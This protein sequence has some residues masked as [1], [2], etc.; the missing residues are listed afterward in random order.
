MKQNNTDTKIRKPSLWLCFACSVFIHVLIVLLIF[1]IRFDTA[2]RKVGYSRKGVRFVTVA[3][4]QEKEQQKIAKT[5]EKEPSF[6]KT[7]HEQESPVRPKNPD[8]IGSR[9][10]VASGNGKS[11][12][13]HSERNLPNTDGEKNRGEIVLFDQE[14]QEGNLETEGE[15]ISPG[16]AVT[17]PLSAEN[18][19]TENG[20]LSNPMLPSSF[21]GEADPK[22]LDKDDGEPKENRENAAPSIKDHLTAEGDGFRLTTP[23]D[24]EQYMKPTVLHEAIHGNLPEETFMRQSQKSSSRMPYDPSFTASSQP[25]F[26]TKEKRTR[27]TGRFVLGSNP[28][29]NVEK[30]P[31]G[32]YQALIYRRIAYYWYRECDANRDMIIPG[33]LQVRLLVNVRGQITS[34]DVEKRTGASVSQQGFTF[35]AIRCAEIPPMPTEVQ[36][37]IVGDKM[38]LIFDFYFD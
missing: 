21:A 29:L 1:P 17:Q 27:T 8:Y 6:V 9:H 3:R 35:R 36:R 14:R 24:L 25:G 10:T 16:A 22:R 30:T 33:S 18:L 11:A 2:A 4:S 7:A 13:E 26:R 32:M 5:P 34:M 31:K 12:K 28:S 15:R 37:D 23:L 38:E 19:L 20:G